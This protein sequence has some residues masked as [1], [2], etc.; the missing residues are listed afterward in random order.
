MNLIA[1]NSVVITL[2]EPVTRQ[3]R[4]ARLRPGVD[5]TENTLKLG[6]AAVVAELGEHDEINRP[7]GVHDPPV[8]DPDVDVTEP[9][10]PISGLRSCGDRDLD[11]IDV[12][13]PLR[14]PRGEFAD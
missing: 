8:G 14:E 2:A 7:S 13:T 12:L 4:S 6:D 11:G 3:Q 1:M 9:G 10:A 5:S